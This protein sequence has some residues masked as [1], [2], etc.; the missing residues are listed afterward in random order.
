MQVKRKT[1]LNFFIQN[2]SEQ[3]YMPDTCCCSAAHPDPNN[4]AMQV[5]VSR[6]SASFWGVKY[7]T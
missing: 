6:H 1:N 4:H 7:L 3:P 2:F 5:S